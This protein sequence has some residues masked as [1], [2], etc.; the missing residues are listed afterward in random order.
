MTGKLQNDGPML[1][2]QSWQVAKPAANG[3]AA[4]INA[5]VPKY[6][7]FIR[8]LRLMALA[9]GSLARDVNLTPRWTQESHD[10]GGRFYCILK[11][12][13]GVFGNFFSWIQTEP[14]TCALIRLSTDPANRPSVEDK[15][16]FFNWVD[17]LAALLDFDFALRALPIAWRAVGNI[18][19]NPA[20][21]QT[22]PAEAPLELVVQ[23]F[24][25]VYDRNNAT[26]TPGVL[27]TPG[28]F[29]I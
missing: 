19:N 16:Q 12:Y 23:I 20:V 17:F 26:N 1:P 9:L 18:V 14:G 25:N 5:R 3:G 2:W 13:R 8:N 27:N 21:Q 6:T 10:L 4:A 29:H 7:R 28:M 24:L 11:Y 22:I 15:S